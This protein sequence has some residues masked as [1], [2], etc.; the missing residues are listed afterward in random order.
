M[1][2]RLAGR[3]L[4]RVSGG[5]VSPA[6]C[7]LAVAAV[8]VTHAAAIG[9][10]SGLADASPASESA[11]LHEQAIRQ[12]VADLYRAMTLKDIDLMLSLFVQ[13]DS[14]EDEDPKTVRAQILTEL[15][16]VVAIAGDFTRASLVLGD[17]VAV[18][19]LPEVMTVKDP[20]SGAYK[21]VRANAELR[22]ALTRSG[23]RIESKRALPPDTAG[24]QA[25]EIGGRAPDTTRTILV[26]V[27]PVNVDRSGDGDAIEASI[28]DAAT[29]PAAPPVAAPLDATITVDALHPGHVISPYVYGSA[30]GQWVGKLPPDD[31]ISDLRVKLIRFGGNNISRY[32]WRIDTY[33]DWWTKRNVVQRPGLLEFVTWA[34]S[35]GAEPLIQVNAFG[36]AP[37]ETASTEMVRIM[38]A[39]AAAD[40]VRFLNIQHGLKVRFFEIDNEPFIWHETHRDYQ[41]RPIGYD[42]YLERFAEFSRAMKAVDPSIIVMGPANCN[43]TYYVRSAVAADRVLKGDWIPYMLRYCAE[44]EGR[45]GLRILDAVSFHRYP[46]YRSFNA[47]EVHTNPQDIL[48]ATREWWDPS[49]NPSLID[50]TSESAVRGI[51]PLFGR[52]IDQNYPG[53]GLALTEYNLDFD[54]SVEYP[55][56]VRA[57]WLAETIGQLARHDVRYGVYWNLQE[58]AE[59][60]LVGMDGRPSEAYYAFR[61]YSRNLTGRMLP[62]KG[63]RERVHAFAALRDDGTIAVLLNTLDLAQG[64]DV[65]VVISEVSGPRRVRLSLQPGSVAALTVVPG[66]GPAT[67]EVFD[68]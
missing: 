56:G 61:L 49:Y 26:A 34:R 37:A 1:A 16:P 23:W 19:R 40:L 43:P 44:Y 42:E 11:A 22:L 38:D 63:E 6:L 36:F 68:P 60:G 24:S 9:G 25:S 47:K 50:P 53:T 54:S 67:A 20:R 2:G 29:S 55:P 52:W 46:I 58:G 14:R 5:L 27:E 31:E 64:H 48:D 57:L 66:H 35:H 65:E 4:C 39:E 10:L 59:H 51:L 21:D 17:G 62:V 33:N 13:R 28:A 7:V 45:H 3:R 41:K 12:V 15:E 32:N 18:V 8:V 30:W